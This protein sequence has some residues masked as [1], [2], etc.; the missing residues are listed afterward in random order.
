MLFSSSIFADNRF[1]LQVTHEVF[2][3]GDPAWG[4]DQKVRIWKKGQFFIN[5]AMSVY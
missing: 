4:T 3:H 5:I 1:T 2:K